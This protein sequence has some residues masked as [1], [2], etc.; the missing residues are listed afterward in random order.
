M[1]ILLLFLFSLSS[2]A[3]WNLQIEGEGESSTLRGETPCEWI[4]MRFRQPGP[5]EFIIRGGGYKC[6]MIEAEYPY[7]TFKIE[8]GKL[9]YQGKIHG[10]ISEDRLHL[11]AEGGQYNLWVM[12]K[13]DGQY[14]YREL[15]ADRNDFFMVEGDLDVF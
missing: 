9:V 14:F 2:F 4:E 12:K 15:W 10:E 1:K 13:N 11:T 3:N 7:S 6:G 8:N 5:S